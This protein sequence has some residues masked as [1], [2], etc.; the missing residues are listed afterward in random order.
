VRLSD[1]MSAMG[2]Q[3]WAEIGLVLFLALFAG[4]IVY[5]FGPRRRETFDQARHM[6]LDEGLTDREGPGA[7]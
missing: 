3:V 7:R 2:L 5:T 6:P 1:L 4:V